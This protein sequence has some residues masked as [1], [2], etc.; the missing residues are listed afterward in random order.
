MVGVLAERSRFN[1]RV[2]LTNATIKARNQDIYNQWVA[3]E[4]SY[5][6]AVS[7]YKPLIR[8]ASKAKPHPMVAKTF[9]RRFK[10]SDRKL[11]APAHVLPY[12]HPANVRY[13]K[14]FK[15]RLK[16]DGVNLLLLLNYD[17]VWRLKYR[18]SGRTLWK[19]KA[20]AGKRAHRFTRG[21]RQCLN[22]LIIK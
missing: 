3:G 11:T 9:K 17:Q 5:K 1:R 6:E 15:Y 21:L 19:P 18:G 8:E 7:Q 13:R 12:E 2:R 16:Q 14:E 4:R 22:T 20:R 10:W